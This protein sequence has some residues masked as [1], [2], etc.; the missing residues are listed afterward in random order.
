MKKQYI[1]PETGSEEVAE[2]SAL[3]VVASWTFSDETVGGQ[4]AK[5]D[6]TETLPDNPD[7]F[8]GSDSTAVRKQSAISSTL[9]RINV[10]SE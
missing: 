6:V 10:W 1:A 3:L 4:G 2:Q 8:A 9:P 5:E 7:P